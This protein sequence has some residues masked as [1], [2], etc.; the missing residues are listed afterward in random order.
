MKEDENKTVVHVVD[1]KIVLEDPI[2]VAII[3]VKSLLQRNIGFKCR[4]HRTF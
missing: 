1:G 4:P 2:V 3:Q